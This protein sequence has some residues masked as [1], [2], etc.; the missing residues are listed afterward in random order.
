MKITYLNF[1]YHKFWWKGAIFSEHSDYLFAIVFESYQGITIEVVAF[2]S[3]D[4]LSDD[5]CSW[6]GRHL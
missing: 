1:E 3:I 2:H 4:D 6:T 5:D